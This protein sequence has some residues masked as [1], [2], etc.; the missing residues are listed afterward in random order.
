MPA[1]LEEEEAQAGV[2]DHPSTV[3]APLAE[4]P[5]AEP[6][7]TELSVLLLDADEEL[8]VLLLVGSTEIAPLLSVGADAT[9]VDAALAMIEDAWSFEM[10]VVMELESALD[11]P[12]RTSW[13]R[14]SGD[15]SM[16]AIVG[17]AISWVVARSRTLLMRGSLS[18]VMKIATGPLTP[19]GTM[20]S[21]N[22]RG[23]EK[24]LPPIIIWQNRLS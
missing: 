23:I 20:H 11:V 14:S 16:N 1:F 24:G 22:A 8:S 7:F 5:V 4:G 6:L 18:D 10:V 15:E 21:L 19:S 3:I 12:V 17:P 13:P 2:I 9:A